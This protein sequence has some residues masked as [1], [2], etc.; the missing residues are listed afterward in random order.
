MNYFETKISGTGVYSTSEERK[1]NNFEGRRL[2]ACRE[3]AIRGMRTIIYHKALGGLVDLSGLRTEIQ[4]RAK[5]NMPLGLLQEISEHT[6]VGISVR[7]EKDVF[8]E[9]EIP[10]IVL[11]GGDERQYAAWYWTV[12]ACRFTIAESKLGMLGAIEQ[13]PSYRW[14]W[15]R[16]QPDSARLWKLLVEDNYCPTSVEM[17][18]TGLCLI[19]YRQQTQG[20]L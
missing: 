12:L 14:D 2:A 5:K 8:S 3:V 6:G 18:R 16:D 11:E 9:K 7:M 19:E 4:I 15:N 10:W 17:I 13:S 1:S 20:R